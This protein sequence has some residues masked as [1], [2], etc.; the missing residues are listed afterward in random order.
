MRLSYIVNAISLI[1][2]YISLVLLLP[3][4]VALIS[5]D[6]NSVLPFI[7][8]AILAAGFGYLM[9]KLVPKSC[10]LENL[11]DIKKSEALFIV[12][13]SWI[14][15]ALLSAVPYLFYNLSI[16]DSLF[17]ATSGITTTGAT[18]L[19]HY[20]YPQAFFFWRSLSQWLGGLGIIVL[21][22]AVLPQF[23]VAG[24]QMFFA[25]TPGPTEDKFT[26]RVRNTASI[27]WKLYFMLTLVLILLLII[28]GMPVFDAI[29]NSF[30]TISAGGFSP[31]SESIMGYRSSLQTWLIII[32]MFFAGASFNLE[33]KVFEKRNP[34][35]FFKSDEFNLYL[36]VVLATSVLIALILCF[37]NNYNI[38]DAVRHSLFQVISIMTS[39]GSGSADYTKWS[40]SAQ[41]MLFIVMFF[42]SCASSAG[43]GIKM[44]RWLLVIKSMKNEIV[45]ILHPNAVVTVKI[46]N[47]VVAPE[48]LRQVV[49]FVFYYFFTF[50][51]GA[52]LI[53]L[54]EQSHTVGLAASITALGNI[55]PGFGVNGPMGSFENVHVCSKIIMIV[56]MLVGRLELI[57]FLIMFQKDFWNIKAE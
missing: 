9:R 39:T 57:P 3:I 11:N 18:I 26:P 51:V 1:M 38:A 29:C 41:V 52:I 19:S 10:E 33:Y 46:D 44:T 4:I 37:E 28:A 22:V 24:R 36:G 27:L 48:V 2:L 25:E 45:R 56:N 17:E 34:L 7:S 8:A 20:N 6:F 55:G 53:T 23:A 54:I 13:A 21:F 31:N 40:Y 50:A 16:V 5:K 43:G 12:A 15:F 47:N 49:V 14:I 30:S 32:F 42:G 35:L